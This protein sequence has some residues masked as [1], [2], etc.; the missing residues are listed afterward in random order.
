MS[1]DKIVLLVSFAIVS[2][3]GYLWLLIRRKERMNSNKY[4]LTEGTMNKGGKNECPSTPRPTKRHGVIRGKEYDDGH[5][6]IEALENGDGDCKFCLCYDKEVPIY[7]ATGKSIEE[8]IGK[9]IC[10]NIVRLRIY[11]RS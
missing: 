1:E 5:M 9:L 7:T 3:I 4:T 11:E 2:F 10:D 6:K 8:A